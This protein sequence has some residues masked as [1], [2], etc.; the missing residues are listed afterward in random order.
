MPEHVVSHPTAAKKTIA[1]RLVK[2]RFLDTP[3]S[4]EGARRYGGRWNPAGIGI[5]YTSA[6]PELALLE[7]LVHL[8]ALPYQDLPRLFLITLTFP[9]VP[10]SVEKLSPK[11]RDPATYYENHQLLEKW[12]R[13]PD[14]MAL[15]VPSAVV[16][17]SYNFLLHPLHKDYSEIEILSTNAFNIDLRLWNVRNA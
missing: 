11:W 12:L 8:P 10:K 16:A 17:E 4:T 9:S 2:E 6:S 5:L 1:Y 7:Q 14:V 15:M 3:L 13:D